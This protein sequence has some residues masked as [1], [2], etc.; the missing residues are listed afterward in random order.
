MNGSSIT[1][2]SS[3][4]AKRIVFEAQRNPLILAMKKPPGNFPEG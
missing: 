3:V 2:K 1:G 4:V